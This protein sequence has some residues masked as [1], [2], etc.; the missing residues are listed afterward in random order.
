[1]AEKTRLAD[2][3]ADLLAFVEGVF[4]DQ[5]LDI[6]ERIGIVHGE[7]ADD[8][9]QLTVRLIR[10]FVGTPDAEAGNLR[11]NDY[12][13]VAAWEI[14]LTRC[15]TTFVDSTID[16]SA[17]IPDIDTLTAEA[18]ALLT[19]GWAIY[20]GVVD[21]FESGGLFAACTALTLGELSPIGPGGDLA[22][23]T[24]EVRAQL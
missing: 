13:L 19:D 21:G 12:G 20:K 22:G 9:D 24:I 14:R 5:G 1:M 4:V 3:A 10:S 8:C 2:L 15:I 7:S 16:A 23:W 17:A 11:G 6:P 18:S